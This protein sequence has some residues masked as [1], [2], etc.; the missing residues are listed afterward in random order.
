MNI[1][2]IKRGLLYGFFVWLLPFIVAFVIF[3]IRNDDRVFF[4][5]IM[6]VVLVLSTVLFATRYISETEV[7]TKKEAVSLGLLWMAISILV[8]FLFF[9]VGPFKMPFTDYWKDIGFTYIIIPTIVY[10]YAL[11]TNSKKIKDSRLEQL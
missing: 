3:P 7:F 4:E 11:A 6:P 9:I 10:G 2:D 1:E 5:S 8:D